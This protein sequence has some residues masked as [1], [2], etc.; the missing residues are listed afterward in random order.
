MLVDKYTNS[1][2][3]D[4]LHERLSIIP[5]NAW[6]EEL[7]S[8]EA[9]IRETLR[10]SGSGIFL[11]RNIANDIQIGDAT[12]RRGDFLAYQSAEVN[13]NP[14]I[15][16]D[17]MTFDPDRY[18]PGREE[19]KEPFGYLSWGAGMY[20]TTSNAVIFLSFMSLGRHPCLGMKIA[21]LEIKLIL[22]MILLGYEYEIVD[23]NGNYP[24]EVPSQDRNDLLQVSTYPCISSRHV[25]IY[26]S[27]SRDLWGTRVI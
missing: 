25:L 5:L 26:F 13:L 1:T 2:F 15:Y 11:R 22:A 23:G 10:I 4:S 6:E 21:K 14:D 24:K 12:L 3:S 17:P 16:T 9:I 19:G 18:G 7:P 8:L 20:F 27:C